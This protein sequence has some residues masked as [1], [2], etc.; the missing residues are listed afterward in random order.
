[1]PVRHNSDSC[2]ARSAVKS[3][4]CRQRSVGY[5]VPGV[6]RYYLLALNRLQS[7][8]YRTNCTWMQ[9][10]F[11]F[12]HS[13]DGRTQFIIL[14]LQHCT[15]ERLKEK[16]HGQALRSS[17]VL[18]KGYCSASRGLDTYL[19]TREQVGD[20]AR[21]RFDINHIS[22]TERD[23]LLH[24]R[25]VRLYG[26]KRGVRLQNGFI[27]IADLILKGFSNVLGYDRVANEGCPVVACA[28]LANRIPKGREVKDWEEPKK[29]IEQLWL[30]PS[31][32]PRPDS[33]SSSR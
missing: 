25:E 26:L 10:R 21:Q 9:V 19:S 5:H 24:L 18:C 2:T 28:E 11:R 13:Q 20:S 32:D 8:P 7:G 33:G 14:L 30:V 17:A 16:Q 23:D 1:M 15:Q 12:L 27:Q 4:Y 3:P 22:L 31:E 29:L 6:S